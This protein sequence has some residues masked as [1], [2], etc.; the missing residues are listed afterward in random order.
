MVRERLCELQN[1]QDREL[2]P[3]QR[4]WFLFLLLR[5]QRG[6]FVNGRYGHEGRCHCGR[7]ERE[8]RKKEATSRKLRPTCLYSDESHKSMP[9]VDTESCRNETG[10]RYR[11]VSVYVSAYRTGSGHSPCYTRLTP[12][13]TQDSCDDF[14]RVFSNLLTLD[15]LQFG[16]TFGRAV[17]CLM[18]ECD[19]ECDSRCD[20]NWTNL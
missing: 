15:W 6:F 18:V 17:D 8:G 14:H 13:S 7:G 2:R 11:T 5:Q 12:L 1:Q 3:G 10:A 20:N 9:K 19:S 4:C 16:Y